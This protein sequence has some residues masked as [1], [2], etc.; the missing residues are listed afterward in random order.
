MAEEGLSLE[1]SA[2]SAAGKSGRLLEWL[3]KLPRARWRE[4]DSDG[5]TLLHFAC[6]GPNVAAAVVLV[7]SGLVDVNARTKWGSAPT[8]WTIWCEQTRML[9]V[10]CAAG[11]YLQARNNAEYT[12]IVYALRDVHRH[13]S[14]TARVLLAN[15]V[16]LST[17]HEGYR[18]LITP[19]LE[20]FERG[21]LRSRAAVVAMLRVKKAGQLWR[22]DKFL[23]RELAYAVWATRTE[24]EW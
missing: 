9:E 11:A 1:W 4:R 21:V 6:R 7:Q 2:M 5:N 12:P 18:D 19:E 23:L 8:H 17:V 20:A 14:E 13:R 3:V 10:M 24:D 15:G 16:R 22:W